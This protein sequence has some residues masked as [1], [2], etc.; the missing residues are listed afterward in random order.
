MFTVIVF[1]TDGLVHEPKLLK[2][3]G[4]HKADALAL[5]AIARWTFKPATKDGVPVPV[6]INLELNPRM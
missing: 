2:S 4:S 6:Y 5:D 3:S 1:G